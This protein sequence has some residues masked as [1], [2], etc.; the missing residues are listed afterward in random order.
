MDAAR[1]A[2]ARASSTEEP[3][4]E[5]T[6]TPAL[7][8]RRA[9]ALHVAL[10]CALSA[11]V[12]WRQG[13]LFSGAVDPVVAAKGALTVVALAIA[14]YLASTSRARY[15]VGGRTL[16]FGLAYLVMSCV[17]AWPSGT[18]AA[19]AVVAVR[20]GLLLAV[21]LLVLSAFDLETVMLA[22]IRGVALLTAV[23]VLT[24]LGSLASGRLRGGFPALSPNDMAFEFG[25]IALY[26]FR[27]VVSN[28][29]RWWHWPVLL[30]SLA[31]MWLTGS[32]TALLA[33]VVALI[34]MVVQSRV[35]SVPVFVGL[36]ASVPAAVYLSFGTE[37]VIGTLNRGGSENVLTLESRTIAWNAALTMN[38]DDWARWFGLG[39][40]TKTIPVSGQ[41]WANQVLDSTWMSALV[42]AGY[43]GV[44]L[45]L[46]WVLV[47]CCSA[48]RV[49]RSWRP[50]FIGALLFMVIRSFLESGL[51]DA[52][53][54]FVMLVVISATSE[55]VLRSHLRPRVDGELHPGRS[56]GRRYESPGRRRTETA[57]SRTAARP[58]TKPSPT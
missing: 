18:L 19:S 48:V 41:Y 37:A 53:M 28:Q 23:S 31:L 27:R 5:A 3:T 25:F 20:I 52:S 10:L 14:A 6:D 12:S 49:D 2:S 39:L 42:Q 29:T 43:L 8:V 50:F 21:L 4:P 17:G 36:V 58:V 56:V 46:I 1:S 7:P 26:L 40:S 47:V 30:M 45:L 16:W 24:G 11:T 57:W 35:I 34:V 44:L 22:L 13:V 54:A 9:V 55:P 15:P 33:L 38:V 51:F 32:R